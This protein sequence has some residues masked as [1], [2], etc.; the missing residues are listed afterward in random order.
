MR[1]NISLWVHLLRPIPKLLH[2]RTPRIL[3]IGESWSACEWSSSRPFG[4]LTGIRT[5]TKGHETDLSV[6]QIVSS[7]HGI[8]LFDCFPYRMPGWCVRYH[9]VNLAL[10][11]FLRSGQIRG[12]SYG[13]GTVLGYATAKGSSQ[14][15]CKVAWVAIIG[16]VVRWQTGAATHKGSKGKEE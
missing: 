10:V 11:S 16:G 9:R 14:R 12:L 6:S 2:G 5:S 4:E 8:W 3:N 13:Y 15:C 7:Y 1:A